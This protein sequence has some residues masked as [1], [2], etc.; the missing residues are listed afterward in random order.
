LE[1]RERHGVARLPS[2]F[3]YTKGSRQTCGA[4]PSGVGHQASEF[5]L[6]LPTLFPDPKLKLKILN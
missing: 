6:R 4:M 1:P 5:D 3:Q 2:S